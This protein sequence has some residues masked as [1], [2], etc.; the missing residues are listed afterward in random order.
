MKVVIL[1]GVP[2]AGKSTFIKNQND[3]DRKWI[4]SADHFFETA[5]GKYAFD[6]AKLGS[7]HQFCLRKFIDTVKY[8]AHQTVVYVDNT[9]LT[10]AEIAPYYQ[11]A[12]AYGHDVEIVTFDIDAAVAAGRNV[13]S[14]PTR[15]IERMHQRLK[16]AE[17]EFP[18]RWNH[19][20][21]KAA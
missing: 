8:P 9:N 2:G 6:A 5:D 7:A 18:G 3:A 21:I 11:I 13:H 19:R 17:R 4:C 14:V 15:S 16:Q 1:R 10:V 12:E 20:I